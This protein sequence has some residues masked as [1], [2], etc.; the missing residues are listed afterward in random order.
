M[1]PPRPPAAVRLPV[2]AVPV[3][4]LPGTSGASRARPCAG[5]QGTAAI[6]T[7]ERAPSAAA[8]VRLRAQPALPGAA[9][10]ARCQ[11]GTVA[12]LEAGRRQP[13]RGRA[14]VA[15]PAASPA[16][17]PAPAARTSSCRPSRTPAPAPCP[18]SPCWHHGTLPLPKPSPPPG[19]AEACPASTPQGAGLALPGRGDPDLATRP[20]P[21]RPVPSHPT[22]S[23]GGAGLG[24]RQ[25]PGSL[26]A[27]AKAAVPGPPRTHP[28]T[29]PGPRRP[30]T[31]S[32]MP[33][34]GGGVGAR[35]TWRTSRR[36]SVLRRGRVGGPRA[37]GR[38]RQGAV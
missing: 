16:P 27:G 35:L 21:S 24:R 4:A 1:A 36:G 22:G 33:A 23:E 37:A 38:G 30:G 28:G 34:A 19:Q 7:G 11:P 2:P 8:Q 26:P 17:T 18:P 3:R 29:T 9:P 25:H 5:G 14:V 20:F 10:G 13:C 31:F 15:G 32:A 6:S 12:G